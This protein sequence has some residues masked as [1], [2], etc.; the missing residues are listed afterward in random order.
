VQ[1][2][3]GE[4]IYSSRVR[5]G[6]NVS[7]ERIW[8]FHRDLLRGREVPLYSRKRTLSAVNQRPGDD[9]GERLAAVLER[10]RL[11]EGRAGRVSFDSEFT[12]LDRSMASQQFRALRDFISSKMR[13]SH[14]YQP[15]M[16]MTLLGNKGSASVEKIAKA[17]LVRDQSQLEYYGKIVHAMPGRVLGKNHKLVTKVDDGYELNDFEKLSASEIHDLVSLCQARLDEYLDK[18]G[19]RIFEH[20]RKSLGYV[21]GTL[22]YEILKAARFRCELCGISAEERALEVD[23]IVP[24]NC[25]GSDA[26]S[27]LQALCYSCN[28][29]K[30]DRDDTDFRGMQASYNDREPGCPFCEMPDSRV[31]DEN[32]LALLV[33][34]LYPVTEMHSLVIP[35]RHISSYF[36]LGRSELNACNALLS[37]ARTA[38]KT[39]DGSVTGFNMGVNVGADAGQTVFHCHLHLIPRR[40]GDSED[41]S[42]G[43]RGVIPGSQRY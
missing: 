21:S 19:G 11:V 41:P 26:L 34:D 20:R 30:R 22:R 27:N 4:I 25:G 24:R 7:S 15:V 14:I 29:M 33:Y 42:G 3:H 35:K 2:L 16:L 31:I 38:I 18:R 8:S 17:F 6:P 36:E 9:A 37:Q 1:L 43:V 5:R 32:E 28:A 23:H 13:M 12:P 40:S 39:A 10:I